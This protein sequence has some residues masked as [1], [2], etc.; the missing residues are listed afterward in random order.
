[1]PYFRW[2]IPEGDNSDCD[3]IVDLG[4]G[5]Y[6]VQLHHDRWLDLPFRLQWP[7]RAESMCFTPSQPVARC[8]AAFHD[9]PDKHARVLAT[10]CR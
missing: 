4:P 6:A 7:R 10:F 8:L 2:R 9:N 5:K 1:M 3:S